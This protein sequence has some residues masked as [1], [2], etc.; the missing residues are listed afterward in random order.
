MCSFKPYLSLEVNG[1]ASDDPITILHIV[2]GHVTFADPFCDELRHIVLE[3]SEQAGAVV[4]NGGTY[5]CMEG[6]QFSTRAESHFYRSA[7]AAVVIGMTALPE[8]K[9]A[10]EAEMC[11]AMLAMGTDYDCWHEEEEDV[12]IGSVLQ[13]LKRNAELA[14]SVV[15][16]VATLLHQESDCACLEAARYAIVTAPEYIS[17]EVKQ[18]L[19]VLYGH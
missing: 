7:T 6:P 19:D 15:Q 18:K 9:L 4:H 14:N 2:V 16:E 5:I 13:I 8:A 10:R 12:D 17:G 11:Y 1:F 3:A